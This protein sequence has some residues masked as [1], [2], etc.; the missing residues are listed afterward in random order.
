M[1]YPMG[2]CM[3]NLRGGPSID[4]L[5]SDSIKGEFTRYAVWN[6]SYGMSRKK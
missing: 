6:T 5:V 3:G 1:I 4:V 2:H